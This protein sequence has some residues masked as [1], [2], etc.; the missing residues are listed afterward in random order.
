MGEELDRVD[1]KHRIK[2]AKTENSK[3]MSEREISPNFGF[4]SKNCGETTTRN[5]KKLNTPVIF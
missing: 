1:I 3:V 4:D 5:L 2:L